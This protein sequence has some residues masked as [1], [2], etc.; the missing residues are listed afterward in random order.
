MDVLSEGTNFSS[1]R[2]TIHTVTKYKQHGTRSLFVSKQKDNRKKKVVNDRHTD[3]DNYNIH[4]PISEALLWK[5][6]GTKWE[7][8]D[9]LARGTL[10]EDVLTTTAT[11][12]N[13]H[14]F[15]SAIYNPHEH[16]LRNLKSKKSLNFNYKT[17]SE[18]AKSKKNKT[19]KYKNYTYNDSK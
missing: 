4:R 2:R 6:R 13:N 17:N 16:S 14:Y 8:F 3:F 11:I 10:D 15:G 18:N 1:R 7:D 5:T 12:T 9:V 19:N